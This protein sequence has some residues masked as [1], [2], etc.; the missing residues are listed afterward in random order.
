[1]YYD[2]IIGIGGFTIEDAITYEKQNPGTY[3]LKKLLKRKKE[4]D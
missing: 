1:M 3:N 2:G 4:A